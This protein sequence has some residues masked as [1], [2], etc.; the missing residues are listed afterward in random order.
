MEGAFD[1]IRHDDA[2]KAVLQKGVH[3]E[4]VCSILRESCD[5]KG[6]ID[7][8][9]ALISPGFLYARGARQESVEGPDMWNKVLDNVLREPAVRCESEG[10]GFR[11]ATENRKAQKRRRG[12]SG[13]ATKIEGRVLHHLCWADDLYATAGTQNHLTRILE[14][15]T[16]AIER[17]GM[18]WK[19]RSLTIVDGPFT[20]YKPGDVVEVISNSGGRHGGTG[21]VA[22]QSWLLGGQHVA[23]NLQS[24][25]HCVCEDGLVLRSQTACQDAYR[26]LLL[27]VC[28][29]SASCACC[30]MANGELPK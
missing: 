10:V 25:L 17:L 2:E 18:Q 8:L 9:G 7:L 12:T 1:C 16:N 19:E 27:H 20:E 22:G 24:E 13:E 3:P 29:C 30:S 26:C 23:Q 28:T 4:A 15:I 6:R 21:H 14:D 11:P 5:L